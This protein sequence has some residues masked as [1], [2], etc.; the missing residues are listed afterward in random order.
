MSDPER[1]R[2]VAE[3]AERLATACRVPA[4]RECLA[5][6]A[7]AWRRLETQAEPRPVGPASD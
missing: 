6:F 2:R 1:F 7:L 5:A 3:E 4:E